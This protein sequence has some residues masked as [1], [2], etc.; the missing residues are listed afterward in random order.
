MYIMML[1]MLLLEEK[2][3]GGLDLERP[4]RQPSRGRR[5]IWSWK[6]IR[7]EDNIPYLLV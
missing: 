3:S 2:T 6:R 7:Q 5:Q 1:W 4:S